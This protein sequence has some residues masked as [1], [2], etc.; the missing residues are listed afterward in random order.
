MTLDIIFCV[1]V[2]SPHSMGNTT[3]L[4]NY[5]VYIFDSG[6]KIYS[7]STRTVVA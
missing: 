3:Q 2:D 7:M 5:L 4:S 1:E 6:C